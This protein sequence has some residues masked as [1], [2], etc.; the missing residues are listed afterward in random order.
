MRQHAVTRTADQ[1][2]HAP[3]AAGRTRAARVVVIDGQPFGGAGGAPADGAAAPLVLE[4]AQVVLRLQGVHGRCAP[5]VR[6]RFPPVPLGPPVRGAARARVRRR[7]R[8]PGQHPAAVHAV[9]A[10][11]WFRHA[12]S[13][14]AVAQPATTATTAR[15]SSGGTA[16]PTCRYWT[17]RVPCHG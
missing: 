2:T 15:A 7:A 8:P 16:S 6:G 12:T 5:A 4:Q 11:R 14:A 10:D 3:A 1:P 9:L 13:S 17:V